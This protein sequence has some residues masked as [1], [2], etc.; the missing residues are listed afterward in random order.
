MKAKAFDK[1]AA[2]VKVGHP[3]PWTMIALYHGCVAWGKDCDRPVWHMDRTF[4]V[5]PGQV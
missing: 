1:A 4:R 5:I 2:V 3:L